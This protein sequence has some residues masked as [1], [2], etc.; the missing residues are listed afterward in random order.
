[1]NRSLQFLV[2]AFSC[3]TSIAGAKLESPKDVVEGFLSWEERTQTSGIPDAP[4]AAELDKYL[5]KEL[6][7][8]LASAS[9]ANDISQRKA[10]TDKPPFAEGNLFLPS[11]WDR[12]LG[13]E[14]LSAQQEGEQARVKIQYRYDDDVFTSELTLQKFGTDWRI[15]EIV[16]GGTCDF[17]QKGGLRASLYAVLRDYP[18]ASAEKCRKR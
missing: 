6:L 7:C 11:A 15:V 13:H 16:R 2:I 8:L 1:M 4:D 17:C 14:I 10:P 5:S 18:D 3:G 9:A 12:P